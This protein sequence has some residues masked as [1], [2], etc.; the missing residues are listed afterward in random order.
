MLESMK[1]A[2]GIV[3]ADDAAQEANRSYAML[4]DDAQYGD[5]PQTDV[6]AARLLMRITSGALARQREAFETSMEE[7]LDRGAGIRLPQLRGAVY[8][9]ALELAHAEIDAAFHKTPESSYAAAE[10]YN[11]ALQELRAAIERGDQ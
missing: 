6:D 1:Q 11:E 2:I 7:D 4:A 3:M 5:A 9:A 8:E 10:E